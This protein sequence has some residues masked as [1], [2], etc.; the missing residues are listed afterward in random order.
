ML[1]SFSFKYTNNHTT[2]KLSMSDQAPDD[3]DRIMVWRSVQIKFYN[4]C[5]WRPSDHKSKRKLPGPFWLTRGDRSLWLDPFFL[6]SKTIKGSRTG[7]KKVNAKI[8]HI[9][10]IGRL[11]IIRRADWTKYATLEQVSAM[12]F[13]AN[14]ITSKLMCD[15]TKPP[16]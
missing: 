12:H 6:S 11:K 1:T 8:S 16:T 13:R 5:R 14:Y 10:C 3:Q 9:Q 2:N 7:G 15:S 4:V